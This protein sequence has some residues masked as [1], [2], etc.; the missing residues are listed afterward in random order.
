MESA[1][2]RQGQSN[3]PFTLIELLVVIAIIAILA[4]MLLPALNKARDKA[5]SIKCTANLKQIGVALTQYTSEYEDYL[6][7]IPRG[8][9]ANWYR[10]RWV[11]YSGI[12]LYSRD[13]KTFWLNASSTNSVLYCPSNTS[14]SSVNRNYTN[15]MA[16]MQV[17]VYPAIKI[18]RI[19]NTSKTL[20]VTDSPG[21]GFFDEFIDLTAETFQIHGGRA[22]AL[23]LAG[24]CTS[25]S[26]NDFVNLVYNPEM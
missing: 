8:A 19:K 18:T 22:N 2:T 16:N 9:P 15:Y 23:F 6:P 3:K 13:N 10:W 25:G 5:K 4:A 14:I 17:I 20:G 12:N 24:N 11:R 1:L 7:C 21:T 26:R